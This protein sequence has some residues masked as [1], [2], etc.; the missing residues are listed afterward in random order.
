MRV[1]LTVMFALAILGPADKLFHGD[2]TDGGDKIKKF[3]T[4]FA[5]LSVIAMNILAIVF[6][7]SI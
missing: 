5:S 1:Y 2:K 4:V 6:V 3:A 7:W